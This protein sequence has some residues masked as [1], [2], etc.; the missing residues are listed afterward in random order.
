[1]Y[2]NYHCLLSLKRVVFIDVI[3]KNISPLGKFLISHC[4]EVG[5]NISIIKTNLIKVPRV[6]IVYRRLGTW[7]P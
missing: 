7:R 5:E 6:Q 1:M 3:F 2:N 4:R